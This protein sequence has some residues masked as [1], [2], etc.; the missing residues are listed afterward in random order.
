MGYGGQVS[1]NEMRLTTPQNAKAS[2]T[3]TR[4]SCQEGDFSLHNFY[5][6]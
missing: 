1:V 3:R 5:Q 2:K 4:N 6:E